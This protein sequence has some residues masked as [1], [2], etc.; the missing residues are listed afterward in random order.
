MSMNISTSETLKRVHLHY[1]PVLPDHFGPLLQ[2]GCESHRIIA[3]NTSIYMY[4]YFMAKCY[5]AN[6]LTQ[7]LLNSTAVAARLCLPS[8][9]VLPFQ[10]KKANVSSLCEKGRE[11]VN[12]QKTWSHIN[13]NYAWEEDTVT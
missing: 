7:P 3:L 11:H 12:R 6:K 1:Q 4:L 10:N 2:C 13:R 8:L 9:L 5:H